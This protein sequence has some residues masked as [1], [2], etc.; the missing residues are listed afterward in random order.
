MSNGKVSPFFCISLHFIVCDERLIFTFIRHF[1]EIGND[2]VYTRPQIIGAKFSVYKMCSILNNNRIRFIRSIDDDITY[3]CALIYCI[4]CEK[5]FSLPTI[6]ELYFEWNTK[7]SNK[8]N[9]KST[10]A[11]KKKQHTVTAK[12][13]VNFLSIN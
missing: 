4:C 12:I 11:Q 8:N 5:F 6:G 7:Q 1:M 10:H 2:F 9:S 13:A 3:Q